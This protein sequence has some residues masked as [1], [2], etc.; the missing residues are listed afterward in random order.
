MRY[1]VTIDLPGPPLTDD[2]ADRAIEALAEHH[3][4]IGNEHGGP[5]ILITVPADSLRQAVATGLALA[6]AASDREPLGIAALAEQEWDRREGFVPV[7][8]LVGATEA[9]Q[10]LGVS[11][12]RIAQMVDE[13]KLPATR[14][15]N[16]FVF[17]RPTIEA[18]AH[19]KDADPA[20]AM[21]AA[22][23]STTPGTYRGGGAA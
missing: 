15:G 3:P 8:E 23:P 18:L 19:H 4:A 2:E 14:A 1:Q 21:G 11:R 10:I 7:P 16:A 5:S 9:A 17:A 6:A 22:V 20:S 12:Q 13:G